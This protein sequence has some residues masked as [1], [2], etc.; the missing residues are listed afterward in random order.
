L[1]PGEGGPLLWGWGDGDPSLVIEKSQRGNH[2]EEAE[3]LREHE[4][5]ERGERDPGEAGRSRSGES[6]HVHKVIG[7]FRVQA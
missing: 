2:V 6:E 3:G 4:D 1:A 7:S 5:Y